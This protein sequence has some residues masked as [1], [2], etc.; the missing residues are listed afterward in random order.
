MR[1]TMRTRMLTLAVAAAL[2]QGCGGA[3]DVQ[4]LIAKAQDYRNRNERSAAVIELKNAVAKQP[5]HAEARFLLGTLYLEIADPASAEKEFRR[6]L[7]HGYDRGKALPALGEALVVSGQYDKL[8]GEVTDDGVQDKEAKAQVLALRGQALLGTGKTFEGRKAL[9]DALASAPDSPPVL[10]ANARLA[11]L[12]RNFDLANQHVERALARDQTNVDAWMM[13]GDVARMSGNNEAAAS[14]YAK[15]LALRPG[16]PV[17]QIA[18]ASVD[19]EMGRLDEARKRVEQVRKAYPGN[20]AALF[21]QAQLEFR[22]RKLTAARDS[23]ALVLKVAPD[24]LPT[25]LLAGAVSAAL[26]S[27]AEAQ[28]HLEKVLQAAPSNRYARKLL[29][30]TLAATGQLQ[31]AREAVETGLR[32]APADAEFLRLAGDVYARNSEFEKAEEYFERAAKTA[33]GNALVRTRLGMSRIALGQ[34]QEGL[35]DLDAASGMDSQGYQADVAIVVSHLRARRFDD[36][37]AAVGK[38]EAKQPKNPLTFNLKAAAY[39]GKNDIPAARKALEHALALQPTYLPAAVNLASFDL[40]D[41]NPAAA[42]KR[43]EAVLEADKNNVQTL[44]ALADLGPQLGASYSERT[45]WLERAVRAENGSAA[46]RIKLTQLYLAGGEKD[47]ALTVIQQARSSRPEDPLV[48]ETLGSVQLAM[49]QKEQAVATFTALTQVA[50]NSAPA[51]HLLGAAQAASGNS[52]AARASLKKAIAVKGDYPPPYALLAQLDMKA[53]R[54]ADAMKV[55][56]ELQK[57]APK[58]A[59]GYVIEGDVLMAQD[60][61]ARAVAAYQA[62]YNQGKTG[63]AAMKLHQAYI[64]TGQQDVADT[65]LAQRLKEFPED[66]FSRT[67][68]AEHA[69]RSGKLN[70]AMAQYEW[71]AAREPYKSSVLNNL[72]WLYQQF[73]DPRA[74][75]TAERAYKAEPGNAGTA[76]TLAM[77][78][79]ERGD[80]RRGVDLLQKAVAAAPGVPAIRYHYAQ[81]LMKAGERS[82]AKTELQQVV[83][84]NIQFPEKAEA[85]RLLAQLQD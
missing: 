59:A 64:R 85:T 76:D 74:L 40:K 14:A 57:Q 4:S 67:Y 50:P 21:T 55:A 7:E 72:A 69:L 33:P 83:N 49:G 58:A 48:L 63:V 84:T 26:G 30:S 46:A 25:V 56:R 12:D 80:V 38:L 36:A 66:L 18:A 35:A 45:A 2:V 11:A 82:R 34:T 47:K 41:K 15:A 17:A 3:E 81:A 62:A 20:V 37:L 61:P 51:L 9:R 42:R 75:E 79:V 10:L 39:S 54:W 77:I 32:Q 52:E 19:I 44:I 65:F 24:H 31:R 60:D 6:A 8:L 70:D 78:L 5:D 73:K 16:N 71:L 29:V 22:E 13:K 1:I 53:G 68:A 23:A 43:L 27:Y 28:A